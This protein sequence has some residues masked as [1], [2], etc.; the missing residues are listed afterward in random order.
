LPKTRAALKFP[1][2]A[3]ATDPFPITVAMLNRDSVTPSLRAPA[4][5]LELEPATRAMLKELWSARELPPAWASAPFPRARAMLP[6]PN[7]AV[8]IAPEPNARLELPT[9]NAY[10][11][12]FSP[13]A[14]AILKAER[15][16]S[17]VATAAFGPA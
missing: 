6:L 4:L 15:G 14:R 11:S 5:A 9:P 10:A 16:R 3:A 7:P 8:A 12:E 13:R 2:P 17:P 1:S